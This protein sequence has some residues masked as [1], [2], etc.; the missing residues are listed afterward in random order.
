[1]V[2][3]KEITKKYLIIILL[4]FF[5]HQNLEAIENKIL[6]KIDSEIVTSIEIYNYSKY[7]VTLDLSLIHI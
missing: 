1:M 4:F 2:F 7:L 5:T 6:F 3:N